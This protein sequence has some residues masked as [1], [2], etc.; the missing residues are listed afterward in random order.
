VNVGGATYAKF[1][2]VAS[3]GPEHLPAED[4]GRF[5]VTKS[6]ADRYVFKVPSLRNVELTAPYFHTGSTFD[7]K[8]AVTV[9]AESQLGAK[10]SDEETTKIAAFLK[11]LT[12]K[13]PEI[14]LPIL[15]PR[16]R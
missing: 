15:P 5:V 14:I 7:L 13:Q 9:M 16:E 1:G 11:T 6:N 2:V 4:A 8:K 12:G 3:P 10:L